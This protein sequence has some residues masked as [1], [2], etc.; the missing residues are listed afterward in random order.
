MG[1]L[2]Y[3][4]PSSLDG[5]VKDADGS[6]DWSMPSDDMIAFL[7]DSM[8]GVSTYLYGRGMYEA[9]K[10]WGTD[11]DSVGTAPELQR[12]A[13]LWQAADKVVY[14]TTLTMVE[15]SRTLLKDHFDPGEVRQLK[16]EAPGD[17]TIEGPGLAAHALREGLVDEIQRLV[18]PVVVGGGTPVFPPALR[19]GLDLAE[20][21]GFSGGV[22]FLRYA[23]R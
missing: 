12:F 20:V 1:K 11:P 3:Q 13:R 14:S 9:M 7:T 2:I 21:R 6:F 23:V 10:I 18:S 15:T 19:L 16:T 22:V 8:D 5:Y 4:I 17:L